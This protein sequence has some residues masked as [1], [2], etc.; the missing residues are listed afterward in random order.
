MNTPKV[1]RR[2]FL[3]LAGIT[4]GGLVVG[5]S[6]TR[7]GAKM[8]A[9]EQTE[10][11]LTPNAFLQITSSNVVRFYCPRDEMGQGVT[12]GLTTLIAEELDV[13]PKHIHVELA[14][15]HE[16]YTN[17]EFG[18]QGTGGSTSI[19]VHFYPL[20]QL[21]ANVRAV[22]LDAAAAELGVARESITTHESHIEVNGARYP[23]GRFVPRAK[24]LDVPEKAALKPK[25]KFKYIGHEFA[26]LDAKAK[27]TGTALYGIDIDIPDLHYAVVVRCPVAGGNIISVDSSAS[28]KV[29]GVTNI[30]ELASGVAVIAE[31]FW[32][33]KK[34]SEI[35]QV[36][37]QLPELAN[38]SSAQIVAD[39]ERLMD[40]EDGDQEV[41]VG[42]STK[43][44]EQA[45]A[46]LENEYWA[47]YLAHAPL[48]P[49]NA[50]VRV[51]N[52]QADV[53]SGTQGPAACQGLVARYAGIDKDKVRVHNVFLGGGFGRRGVLTH[54]V[55]ATQ[56]AVASGKPVK[57]LWTREDDIRNGFYRP[58][59]LMKLKGG[60]DSEGKIIAWSAKRV[61]ANIMPY[62]LETA[63]PGLL[64][65]AVPKGMTDWIAGVSESVFDGWMVDHA[66]IEGLYEDYDF[67]NREVCHVT[68]NHGLPLTYW[69][70][71][72]HSVTAFAKETLID[73]LSE[74]ANVDPVEFR[75]NNTQGNPRLHKVI[76][77]A[78][79][80]MRQMPI[81]EDR[82]LGFSAHGSFNS[83]V[84]QAA[85]VSV[86]NGKIK[87]H[88]VVCVLDCGQ[89]IN[90][91]IVRGQMEGAIM[92]GLTAA[93][94]GNIEI[95]KGVVKQSNFH[96]YPILK[97][98]E[99][100]AVEVIIID[101]DADP[102]GVGEP[103]LPPIAPAV[104]N[105]VYA[106]THQ[107]LRSL[108]LTPKFSS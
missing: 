82:G 40:A 60:I 98:N 59:S 83:Y 12:T 4:G 87:V 97:M 32:Q 105:A 3:K 65:T 42:N 73:E 79:D 7:C 49:M 74:Q 55:E 2:K 76:K 100:P 75:L 61:G 14:N 18:T 85:E 35:L 13:A 45:V 56:A 51:E 107:R 24:T 102:S 94:Y 62:L 52:G 50:V 34:A 58:A 88:K 44:F 10:G 9:L 21:A 38:V 25:A 46:V 104:A 80:K 86:E 66:S 41:A 91:D 93:L 92:F 17:P 103:G 99:A 47:P 68:V 71:V 54:I 67:P 84:A 95:D 30:V 33:A 28:E 19:K 64:P 63:L 1:S 37:W 31:K 8:S 5:F 48:E 23:Y 27:S 53:W 43:A 26:R 108:P 77:V 78:G 90:P 72:G 81:L 6:L 57:L 15:V 70:S 36:E 96:D 16:D 106:A 39:Y 29:D 22:L 89:V 11:T 101:S 69:R 20:R